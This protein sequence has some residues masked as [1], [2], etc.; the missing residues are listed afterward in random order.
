MRRTVLKTLGLGLAAALAGLPAHAQQKPVEVEFY[1]PVAVGG[2]I[3]K[4]I[5]DM[6]AAFHK[7]N[8]DVL[9]RPV[10]AGSYQDSI[11]KALT[12]HRSGNPPQLAV[13]L[14][15]DMFTLID[16]D[17]IVPIDQ[18]AGGEQDKQWLAGF[19][20]A[21]MQNSRTGGHVWGVPFQRSTIVMYYNKDLFKQAGLDPERAPANWDELVQFASKLTRRDA[22]GN[23]TQWGIEIPSGGAFAYWLFQALTTPNDTLLMNEAGNEVYLD[24]PAV[25]EA[26]TYWRDLA[27]KHKVMPPGTIDWGTTPK[28]FLEQ[29]AAIV[30]TTTGNL[31]N[32]RNNAS[33]PFGVAPMPAAKRGGS[34]TG[35]GNF[36]IFKNATPEQQQAALRFAKWATQPERAAEWSIATGYVAVTPAAWETPRMKQYAQEVPAAVVARDQLAV[37]VAEFSTHENQRVTKLLNDALQ[38]ALTG[39]KTPEAAMADAQREADRILRAYR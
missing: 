28:D 16:E 33:F 20:D 19:Y 12:A 11:T 18:L 4:V 3:T 10:Y 14:S 38:A 21:F 26:L 36:Y 15:T 22:N 24:K 29:K 6:A 7:E 8:P 9:V 2:P 5:D 37:S 30:W 39:A 23:V 35:G 17:A 34:P 31:T 27:A 25:I 32:I 13:L 1:Y